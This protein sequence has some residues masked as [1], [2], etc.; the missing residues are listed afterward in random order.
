[1]RRILLLNTGSGRNLGDRA[2][3]LNVVRWVRAQGLEVTLS[4]SAEVPDWMASEFRLERVPLLIHLWGRWPQLARRLHLPAAFERVL[5]PAYRTFSTL[6]CLM[7]SF[8]PERLRRRLPGM[9]GEFV[10]TVADTSLVHFTGGGYLTD[11][12]RTEARAV[13]LTG[14]L[15]YLRGARV[16]MTGQGIGPFSS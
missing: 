16:V 10:R 13:L 1:M 2:M 9:E 6:S 3:L 8:L 5:T 12:G 15:A 4:A 7:L 14:L 11:A